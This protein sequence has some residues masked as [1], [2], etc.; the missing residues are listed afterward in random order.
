MTAPDGFSC[1]SAGGI[2]LIV[3]PLIKTEVEEQ[4]GGFEDLVRVARE[5]KSRAY[6]HYSRFQVGAAV[7]IDG[8]T[9]TGANVEN[10]SYGATLCA[11]R[12]AIAAAVAAGHRHLEI[13]AVSTSAL[14]G[15]AIEQR[16]PCG[17][18]RQVISE[19]AGPGTLVLLDAGDTEDGRIQGEVIAFESLL[20]WRFRLG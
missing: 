3:A 12:N 10:A 8:T 20:P 7:V 11:E 14:S 9:F 4:L 2:W 16:S 15:T 19:F 6:A 13:V 17:I 18:C 1:E 5:A